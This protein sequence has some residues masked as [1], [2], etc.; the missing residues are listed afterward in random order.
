MLIITALA[1]SACK[2]AGV[3]TLKIPLSG[4]YTILI[5]QR[6]MRRRRHPTRTHPKP[7]NVLLLPETRTREKSQRV[8]GLGKKKIRNSSNARCLALTHI[9]HTLVNKWQ[10]CSP[11]SPRT[12]CLLLSPTTGLVIWSSCPDSVNTC[13]PHALALLCII[14]LQIY[15][16]FPP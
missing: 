1:S 10:N 16:P 3:K 6:D 9:Q 14:H 12:L 2:C 15:I 13:A 5:A 11:C 7:K 8:V 4:S